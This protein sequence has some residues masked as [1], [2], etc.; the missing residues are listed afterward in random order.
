MVSEWRKEK[1]TYKAAGFD[2][3]LPS[4]SGEDFE[5][6]VAEEQSDM[7]DGDNEAIS[8]DNSSE[9]VE[10]RL[11]DMNGFYARYSANDAKPSETDSESTETEDESLFDDNVVECDGGACSPEVNLP[12]CKRRRT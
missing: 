9:Y 3:S 4:E 12:L 1:I 8:D 10:E 11:D 5:K 2:S 6:E 7:I